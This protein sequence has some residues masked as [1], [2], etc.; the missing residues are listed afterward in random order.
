MGQGSLLADNNLKREHRTKVA[1]VTIKKTEIKVGKWNSPTCTWAKPAKLPQWGTPR[2]GFPNIVVEPWYTTRVYYIYKT[3][4]GKMLWAPIFSVHFM[5]IVFIVFIVY[6]GLWQMRSSERILLDSMIAV[7]P[8]ISLPLQVAFLH[9][10]QPTLQAFPFVSGVGLGRGKA[11]EGR[12]SPRPYEAF[13]S[14]QSYSRT[15]LA[16]NERERPH[17]RLHPCVLPSPLSLC[18]LLKRQQH[19]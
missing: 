2:I 17:F 12:P 6:W 14:P 8:R 11:S 15:N 4:L 3:L 10:Y 1:M 7:V 9:S 16:W 5:F 18:A 13:S 19:L